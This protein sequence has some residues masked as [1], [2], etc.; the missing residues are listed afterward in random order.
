MGLLKRLFVSLL[1]ASSLVSAPQKPSSTP[2]QDTA[3]EAWQK[4]F[5]DIASKTQ[6]AMTLSVDELK[7]LV[8]RCDALAPRLEKLDET[9]KKV[10]QRRLKQCRGLF[11][12]VLESKQESQRKEKP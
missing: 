2:P 8:Q 10:Y 1:L 7:T 6:D 9:P 3:N 11:A 5:D 4:E 12:Y